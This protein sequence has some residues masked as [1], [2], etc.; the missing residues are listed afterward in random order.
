LIAGNVCNDN[1]DH[2]TATYD[3]INLDT[4]CSGNVVTNNVCERNHN[5]GIVI[6]GVENLISNN[7][8]AENDRAGIYANQIDN[9]IND[10]RVL[11]NGQDAAGTYHGIHLG[12]LSIGCQVTANYIDGYGDSQEDCIHLDSGADG[13]SFNGNYCYDGMGS[14]ICLIDDNDGNH[15][16]GNHLINN[17]DY[18][19]R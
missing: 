1:D 15:L 9:T 5:C 6:R 17:D 11:D 16:E 13:N 3:G 4:G 12:P 2:D 19:R 14:G 7:K 8:T 10:N 18:D